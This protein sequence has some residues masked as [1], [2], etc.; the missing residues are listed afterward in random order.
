MGTF[1]KIK[2]HLNQGFDDVGRGYWL[3]PGMDEPVFEAFTTNTEGEKQVDYSSH[4]YREPSTARDGNL[5]SSLCQDGMHRPVLDLDIP[6]RYEPS[7]TPGHSHL[8]I[9]H[10]LTWEQYEQVLIVLAEVGILEKGYVGAA[11]AREATY[12]RP[13]WVKK[14]EKEQP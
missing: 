3:C 11:I 9:D 8:Y 12:V 5:L 1:G 6:T 14:P 4:E 13:R 7:S 10:P 2:Y